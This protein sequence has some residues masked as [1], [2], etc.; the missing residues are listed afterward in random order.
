MI[1]IK[2]Q[3]T[4]SGDLLWTAE[5]ADGVI[6]QITVTTGST[7]VIILL[8]FKEPEIGDGLIKTAAAFFASAGIPTIRFAVESEKAKTAAFAAGFVQTPNGLELDPANVKRACK[9]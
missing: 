4:G 8:E 9:G 2:R 5:D 1:C 3:E 6:G 7:P